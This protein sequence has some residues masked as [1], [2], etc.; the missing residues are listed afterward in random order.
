MN[1]HVKRQILYKFVSLSVLVEAGRWDAEFFCNPSTKGFFGKHER[2]AL[3]KIGATCIEGWRISSNPSATTYD[4]R[5]DTMPIYRQANLECLNFNLDPEHWTTPNIE[6]SWCV[7]PNDVVLNKV[8][9]VRAAW[10]TP[11]LHQHPIDGNCLLIRDLDR[12]MA[13]WVAI[14]LNQPV[15]AEYL[16][17]GTSLL[18]VSLSKLRDLQVPVPPKAMSSLSAEIW[19]CSDEALI[20]DEAL[21]HLLNEAEEFISEELLTF[22]QTQNENKVSTLSNGMR[23]PAEAIEDSLIPK[24]VELSNNQLRLE[25]ELGWVTLADLVISYSFRERLNEAPKKGRYLR[26]KDV[27]SDL[28]VTEPQEEENVRQAARIYREPLS[29]GEVL[30]STLVTSPRVAFVDELPTS[31]IYVTDHWKRLRFQ[32]TPGAWALVLSTSIVQEQLGNMA[33]G[34][35]QQ[36]TSSAAIDRLRLPQVPLELRSRWERLLRRHH[37]RKRE[38][39]SRWKELLEQAQALFNEVH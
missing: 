14:C 12:E 9:P 3:R 37:Q 39:K 7:K 36:F 16:T 32:E 28:L 13:C 25:R 10:V 23:F 22:R 26:L 21:A 5:I 27:G 8:V 1:I 2:V 35:V 31:T 6:G 19:K 20:N 34:T 38:I 17:S 15:Y 18:R 11:T 30:I 4:S 29:A 33:L 24:H